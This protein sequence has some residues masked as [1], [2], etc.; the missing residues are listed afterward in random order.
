M[1]MQHFCC[2]DETE[3]RFT[4]AKLLSKII[5]ITAVS[6]YLFSINWNVFKRRFAHPCQNGES[7]SPASTGNF[8]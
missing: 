5:V 1:K 3:I 2:A 8:L 6:K 4:N 7:S